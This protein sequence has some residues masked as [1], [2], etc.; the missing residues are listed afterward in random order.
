MTDTL[1]FPFPQIPDPTTGGRIIYNGKIYIG[2]PDTDPTNAVNQVR[3]FYL[4]EA[5]VE[6]DLSQ[7]ISTNT[8][9]L[10]VNPSGDFIAVKI[11]TEYNKYSLAIH[12]R[13]DA[14]QYYIAN[15]EEVNPEINLSQDLSQAYIFDTVALYQAS[16]I[17]FPVGK[18]ID[19]KERISGQ[20]GGGSGVVVLTS[21]VTPNSYDIV[22]SSALPLYSIVI[23]TYSGMDIKT[24]GGNNDNV[25]DNSGVLLR[26]SEIGL[27]FT[28]DASD[29]FYTDSA[30]SD[31]PFFN[32]SGCEFRAPNGLLDYD[33]G[34]TYVTPTAD[35][36]AGD[37]V[38]STSDAGTILDGGSLSFRSSELFNTE[39]AY[40]YNGFNVEV[41]KE[42]GVINLVGSCPFDM[43]VAQLAED[44][45]KGVYYIAPHITRISNITVTGD[46]TAATRGLNV[47]GGKVYLENVY[48]SGYNEGISLTRIVDGSVLN[49]NT[50]E[51]ITY[52][53]VLRSCSN[54]YS[55]GGSYSSDIVG[56]DT[57]G[58][59]PCFGI[60][61]EEVSA[62]SVNGAKGLSMHANM[63][64]NRL[65]NCN[66][67]GFN[68]AGHC[69]VEG[70]VYGS[71]V[72]QGSNYFYMH[73]SN[74][75]AHNSYKFKEV[76]FVRQ[77]TIRL[78]GQSQV[79]PIGRIY[80]GGLSFDG[81]NGSVLIYSDLSLTSSLTDLAEISYIYVK[82]SDVAITLA[83][84]VS[85]LIL[86]NAG[87]SS[88]KRYIEQIDNSDALAGSVEKFVIKNTELNAGNEVI[89]ISSFNR[90]VI[91]NI[92]LPASG[93]SVR[94]EDSSGGI[95]T[96][97]DSDF[98]SA[99]TFRTDGLNRLLSDNN[100]ITINGA[101]TANIV[102]YIQR[103]EY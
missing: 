76:T 73:V 82:D 28:A 57:G 95:L 61:W 27:L 52:G 66:I 65:I 8:N 14:E 39:R 60:V 40:Y 79:S 92:T 22:S 25:T 81:C 9:G 97:R 29:V 10:T 42:N 33:G 11:D 58:E 89:Q 12:D 68:A 24:I 16:T 26:A 71:E 70:G 88:V 13:N 17:E 94:I 55:R 53:A 48:A 54:V 23:K 63:W 46:K 85:N 30:V 64:D 7:P 5:E 56:Y 102:T 98:T 83:D 90:G 34:E 96:M 37:R 19:F 75:D 78:A 31:F 101:Y 21:T 35:Y 4:N 36:E 32:G 47:Y 87:N 103:D 93:A 44:G 6:I 69:V 43:T 41:A 3:C 20:G 72:D 50:R 77:P 1:Q 91:K 45:A 84:N 80:C 99:S 62:I 49:C 15:M 67:Q 2:N 18:V 86:N 74:D 100:I 38:F 51:C 59:E